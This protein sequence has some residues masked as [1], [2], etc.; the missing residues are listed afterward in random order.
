MLISRLPLKTIALSLLTTG[1]WMTGSLPA[2]ALALGDTIESDRIALLE[3]EPST[4]GY[5]TIQ[6]TNGSETITATLN[7]ENRVFALQIRSES[8]AA[9]DP[10]DYMGEYTEFTPETVSV[11]P[12][13]GR[14]VRYEQEGRS[15]EWRVFGMSGRFSVQAVS[16]DLAPEDAMDPYQ[17]GQGSY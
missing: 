7:D 17:A 1:I 3:V 5:R 16:Y 15:A 14:V 10:A 13:R 4:S 8:D 12:L 9:P 6:D 11:I 2:T